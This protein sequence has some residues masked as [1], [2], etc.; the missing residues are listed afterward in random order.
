M[1][2][3]NTDQQL[4]KTQRR[5]M[6]RQEIA[7]QRQG[8][9][10]KSTLMMWIIV[11]AIVVV[12]GGVVFW[13]VQGSN[14]TNSTVT[15]AVDVPVLGGADASVVMT[16]F[17]D[18]SCPACASAAPIVRQLADIYGDRIKIEFRS[19][20][21]GHQWSEKS[22]EA[23]RCALAQGKFWEFA[24]E[25]FAKQA[26]WETA[27]NAVDLFKS[28]AKDVGVDETQFNACLDSGQ[29]AAAIQD[30]VKLGRSKGVSATPT[31]FVNDKKIVG[32]Q[33]IDTFKSTIDAALQK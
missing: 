17:S 19:Y 26:D 22:L 3:Q 1:N 7:Q 13:I 20:D 6:R 28:Y 14:S 9:E 29:T 18:L 23:G 2:E 25:A 16:E 31:F 8:Q 33:S 27:D 11:I 4:T 5:E 15:G 32:A 21:I 30:D 24:D 12:V 10:R